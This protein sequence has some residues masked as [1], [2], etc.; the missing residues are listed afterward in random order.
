MSTTEEVPKYTEAEVGADGSTG[1]SEGGSEDTFFDGDDSDAIPVVTSN[2]FVLCVLGLVFLVVFA[3]IMY[4]V[5]KR[6]REDASKFEFFDRLES[7]QFNIRLPPPVQEY[8]QVKEKAS[9]AGWVPGQGKP[10]QESDKNTPGRMLGQALMKRAIADIPLIQHMQKEAQG[11]YRLHGK[12]MCS[13]VQWRTFQSAEAL[14]SSEVDE[15]RREAEEVEPGWADLIWRQAAQYHGMLKQHQMQAQAQAQAKA[16]A[17]GG[18][19]GEKK[20]LTEE[21]KK[22]RA[23]K[24]AKELLEMEEREKKKG[25]QGGKKK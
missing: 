2:I 23:E 25:K 4:N 17:G 14:V 3:I 13:E 5:Q 21:E 9:A 7:A 15:V 20:A 18:G 1:G 6:K 16:K 24:A 11:M 19:G 22:A 8:Y 10:S 12:N